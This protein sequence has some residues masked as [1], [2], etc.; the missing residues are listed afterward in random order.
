[1][2]SN[3]SNAVLKDDAIGD[4]TREVNRYTD[5]LN[6]LGAT[7]NQLESGI[8]PILTSLGEDKNAPKPTAVPTCEMHGMLGDRNDELA[9]LLN[10][11]RSIRDRVR[12]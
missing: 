4:V 5:L 11:L 1:M 9:T 12:L 2:N 8:K 10:R 3:G 7:M 6:D